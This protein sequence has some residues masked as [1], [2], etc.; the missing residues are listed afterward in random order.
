MVNQTLGI[1]LKS[2]LNEE[3]DLLFTNFLEPLKAV[4]GA[5]TQVDN[6]LTN[7]EKAT[8]RYRVVDLSHA[9][10]ATVVLQAEPIIS[11]GRDNSAAVINEFCNGMKHLITGTGEVL[12]NYS[13]I[14]LQAFQKIGTKLRNHTRL[15]LTYQDEH[16]E[17]TGKLAAAVEELLGEDE[18]MEE[19][20]TG[21]LEM[22]N[23]H[24]RR[25][26]FRI[27]P[28]VGPTKVDCYFPPRLKE[29]SIMGMNRYVHVEGKFKYKR[30]FPYPYAVQVT[31]LE[32][33]PDPETLP[34]LQEL[35]GIAPNATGGLSSEEFVKR[36]HDNDW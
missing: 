15:H 17:V 13:V 18:I 33:Y 3:E 11:S 2:A 31:G 30:C 20:M 9:S 35:C 27:Y 19:S 32:I 8:V 23:L 22:L 25:K 36:I 24:G 1:Q 12:H 14:L 29:K 21:M 26:M 6:H 34:S 5:L 4:Q 28:M 7:T 10:P 16:L